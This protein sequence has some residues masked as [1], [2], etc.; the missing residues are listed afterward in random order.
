[1]ADGDGVSRHQR[2]T[3]QHRDLR[4]SSLLWLAYVDW[5]RRGHI[6]AALLAV[7]VPMILVAGGTI[8]LMEAGSHGIARCWRRIAPAAGMGAGWCRWWPRPRAGSTTRCLVGCT[9][10]T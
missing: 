9:C 10:A 7:A 8:G 2:H 6:V 4:A 5:R 3:P 1:M